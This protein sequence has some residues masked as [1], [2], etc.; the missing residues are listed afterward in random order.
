VYATGGHA[1]RAP[2]VLQSPADIYR[3]D[4]AD[5]ETVAERTLPPPSPPRGPARR[6]KISPDG[7][8]ITPA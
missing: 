6:W 3:Q 2:E 8:V 1:A 4:C 5:P 7:W